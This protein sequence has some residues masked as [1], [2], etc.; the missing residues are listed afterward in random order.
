MKTV[1]ISGLEL[2]TDQAWALAQFVKGL[3]WDGMRACAV[4]DEEAYQIRDAIY[5]LQKA[6]AEAGIEPR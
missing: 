1:I 6:L 4:N 3:S 5:Q 2:S